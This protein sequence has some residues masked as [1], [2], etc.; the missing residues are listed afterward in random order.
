VAN[1]ALR[2]YLKRFNQAENKDSEHRNPFK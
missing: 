1:Q 2:Y